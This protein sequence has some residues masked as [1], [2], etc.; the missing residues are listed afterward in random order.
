MHSEEQ[1]AVTVEIEVTVGGKVGANRLSQSDEVIA[2]LEERLAEAHE[3]AQIWPNSHFARTAERIRGQLAKFDQRS[4]RVRPIRRVALGGR[5]RPGG[6]R[7]SSA[8]SAGGG[9]SDSPPG[10]SDGPG[11]RP[12]H[13]DVLAGRDRLLGDTLARVWG[14][15]R[16]MPALELIECCEGC[17]VPVLDAHPLVTP[18]CRSCEMR[19]M[20][21]DSYGLNLREARRLEA[22]GELALARICLRAHRR[23]IHARRWRRLSTLALTRAPRLRRPS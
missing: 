5:R 9:S 6:H 15:G 21:R 19:E 3:N 23:T 8:R 11:E 2:G 20:R 4:S 13:L 22:A 14:G 17:G 12:R 18:R 10:D 7:R 16:M 1:H